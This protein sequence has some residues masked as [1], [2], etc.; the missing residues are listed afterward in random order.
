VHAALKPVSWS[1]RRVLIER[2][3]EHYDTVSPHSSLGYRPPVPKTI[4]AGPPSAPG[5]SAAA[6]KPAEHSH[7]L[8]TAY[9]RKVIL[10][11]THEPYQFL[12]DTA[13]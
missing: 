4:A 5:G 11:R 12:P 13:K 2:L 7:R 9:R 3:R 6:R 8:R 1:T 10:T